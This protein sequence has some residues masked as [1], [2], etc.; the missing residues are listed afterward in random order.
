MTLCI[1][2]NHFLE[3]LCANVANICYKSDIKQLQVNIFTNENL[4]LRG[5]RKYPSKLF[6]SSASYLKPLG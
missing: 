4:L 5:G 2:L 3:F 1:H 6:S